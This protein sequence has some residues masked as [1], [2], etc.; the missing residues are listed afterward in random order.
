MR[1]CKECRK[2]YFRSEYFQHI[3]GKNHPRYGVYFNTSEE[4]KRKMS[5]VHKGKVYTK[6]H[7]KKISEGLKG[8]FVSEKTRRKISEANKG[9]N[10]FMFG[11]HLSKEAREKISESRKGK[12]LSLKIREK[13]SKSRR[14]K[15]NP[16]WR[17]GLITLN[18]SIR[19][20]FQYRQWR[21]D[22]FYRDEFTCQE[23]G[24]WGGKLHAHHIKSFSS[25]LQY[26]E[27]TT[28]EESLECEELW[29]INNGITLCEEC[30]KSIHEELKNNNQIEIFEKGD[31]NDRDKE[32]Y[33]T[34]ICKRRIV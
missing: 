16:S 9:K 33:S 5:I 20:I 21:S 32:N 7:R 10:N 34:R 25:I 30:H 8:H 11:K 15:L 26:Y 24:Q 12:L 22:I 18:R 4:T 29:N 1:I 27:I 23:C 6:D 2:E 13:M 19:H 17:G 31:K 28:L 3:H 14:G